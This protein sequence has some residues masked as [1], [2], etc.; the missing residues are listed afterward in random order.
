MRVSCKVPFC[1]WVSEY[2][3]H[4]FP[5][6][7]PPA[8]RT[9]VSQNPRLTRHRAGAAPPKPLKQK[10]ISGGR[11]SRAE[12]TRPRSAASFGVAPPLFVRPPHARYIRPTPPAPASPSPALS[13]NRGDRPIQGIASSLPLCR[14]R[15]RKIP[16]PSSKIDTRV[17]P[18]LT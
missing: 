18:P 6:L 16:S 8:H 2:S 9:V 3:R 13:V 10:P 5:R 4:R 17:Y 15:I 11:E 7:S 1:S 14:D 12:G